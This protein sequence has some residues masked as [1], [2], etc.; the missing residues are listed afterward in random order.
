MIIRAKVTANTPDRKRA[1][2]ASK[3]RRSVFSPSTHSP[4]GQI[5]HLQRTI[6]NQAVQRLFRSGIIQAKDEGKACKGSLIRI[7]VRKNK[8]LSESFTK[9]PAEAVLASSGINIYA[10]KVTTAVSQDEDL[11][12]VLT[13]NCPG[14]KS[15]TEKATHKISWTTEGEELQSTDGEK[16]ATD[17][18]VYGLCCKPGSD[19]REAAEKKGFDM[20]TCDW[21][22]VQNFTATT[23]AVS[24]SKILH[25]C[26]WEF[27]FKAAYRTAKG[28]KV[29]K[30]ASV[31]YWGVDKEIE[32]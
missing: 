30:T 23:S 28:G 18:H 20:E 25:R 8:D 12:G 14:G 26:I 24:G 22:F 9:K 29:S 10:P 15:G 7:E 16:L 1:D 3:T 2:S 6:G 17:G 19:V 13:W 5:M 21:E 27:R 32:T 4:I 11:D 31:K